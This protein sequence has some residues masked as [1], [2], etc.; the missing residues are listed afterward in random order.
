[1]VK[2]T[3]IVPDKRSASRYGLMMIVN[4]QK[5]LFC[6]A[7]RRYANI[8]S[9]ENKIYLFNCR[10]QYITVKRSAKRNYFYKAKLKMSN[11]S[12]TSPRKFWEYIKKF[13]NT[14]GFDS[15]ASLDD[16]KN[17]FQNVSNDNQSEF[18]SGEFSAERDETINIEYLDRSISVEEVIKTISSLKR[19]KSCDY[20]NNVSDFLIDANNVI[21][22]Y[23]CTIFNHIYDNCIYPEAWSKGVIVP[24]Y[25]KGDKNI[26]ANYRGITLVNVIGKIFSLILRNRINKWCEK[27]HIFNE[28]QYGFRDERSTSDA[29]FLLHA[30]IQNVLSKKSKLWCV[31]IDYQR[32]FDTVIRDALWTKLL[33]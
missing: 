30:I 24:I 9:E 15:N 18:M 27:E 8:K 32:A 3:I 12:K 6:D 33:Q 21:S 13:K 5:K 23:L 11:I 29:I 17:Y 4:L 7:K 19:Y 22:P 1:M 20:E 2:R 16:F 25:K 26:P 14:N 31:F 10:K 28:S